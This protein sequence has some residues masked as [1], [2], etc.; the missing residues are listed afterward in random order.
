MEINTSALLSIYNETLYVNNIDDQEITLE[1]NFLKKILIFKNKKDDN[2][3][4]KVLLDNM[5]KA[6]KVNAD[7]CYMVYVQNAPLTMHLI[8][9][10][11][12]N[13][14]LSFGVYIANEL[15]NLPPRINKVQELNGAKVVIAMPLHSMINDANARKELWAGLQ[16]IFELNKS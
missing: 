10:Y 13:I 2:A 12:P 5:L 8:N 1:G 4:S 7:D 3:D 16:N 14:V 6:C 15:F 11:S 9:K